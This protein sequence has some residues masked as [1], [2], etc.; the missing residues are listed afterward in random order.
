MHIRHNAFSSHHARST[1]IPQNLTIPIN[2]LGCSTT[3]TELDVLH[4][5]LLYCTGMLFESHD[6]CT[7]ILNWPLISVAIFTQDLMHTLVKIMCTCTLYKLRNA[8]MLIA[9]TFLC[10]LLNYSH[11]LCVMVGEV[12]K[13]YLETIKNKNHSFYPNHKSVA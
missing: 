3:G 9:F 12:N 4:I 5:N 13:F 6:L 2:K 1:V 10:K 8:N 7:Q 11:C